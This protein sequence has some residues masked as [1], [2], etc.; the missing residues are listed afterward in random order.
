VRRLTFALVVAGALAV[1]SSASAGSWTTSV[2]F[3]NVVASSPVP[4]GGYPFD[5]GAPVPGT[6]GPQMLN[7]NRSESWIAVKPG[8]ETAVGASKFFVGK[9]STYYD[10]HLGSYTIE[11]GSVTAQNQV[12]GYE[13]TTLGG[14]QNMPPSWTNNT[15]PNVDFSS[16]GTRIYQ[17]TLP[18]NAYWTNLHP[19]AAVMFSYS[20]DLGRH[21]TTGN[22]GKPLEQSP[23]ASSLQFGH[24]EDKQWVAV[25]KSGVSPFKDRVYAAWAIFNGSSIKVVLA[26][27]DDRGLSFSKP[28]TISA[29]N[30]VGPANTYVIPSVG[31]DGTLYVAM[32]S[33]PPSGKSTS[34]Y[35]LVSHDGSATFTTTTVAS[36]V[37][38]NDVRLP[39]TRFRDGIV[40]SF[41]ASPSLAGHA[42][43]TWED[44]DGQQMDVYFAYTTNWGQTWSP[45]QLVNDNV[46]PASSDQFQPSV[47]AGSNGAVA[48]AFYD[49]REACPSGAGIAPANVGKANFCIDTSLQAYKDSSG[50]VPTKVLG[51]A[52]ISSD[53]WDPEQPQQTIGGLGQIACAS[54]NDP[55]T[56]TFIGDYFGLAVSDGNIYGLFVSTRYPSQVQGDGG[57]PIY[58]QQ[59][60]LAT[61]PRSAFGTGY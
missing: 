48:V 43:A 59:Q 36:N 45:R 5:G 40:E 10:F 51:N 22:G 9:W 19:N 12:Q 32:V 15:D 14:N 54:H 38:V 33:F 25:D 52:R 61:V 20:D 6:C 2:P 29:P 42:Y 16:D 44:W 24:V 56:T 11:N 28:K 58:Y 46:N 39:N 35:V 31:A 8:S 53:T 47:A 60:V 37:G 4:G 41:A 1:V 55:C 18:F 27:S 26:Y 49:R 34:I 7:S 21:W 3:T 23:N 50:G 17:T 57:V 13:C 30:S